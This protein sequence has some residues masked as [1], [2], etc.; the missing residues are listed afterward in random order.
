MQKL[1][2]KSGEIVAYGS[3]PGGS[4]EAVLAFLCF[5]SQTY[6]APLSPGMTETEVLDAL[7]QFNAK[8]LILFHGIECQGVANAFESYAKGGNAT[9]HSAQITGTKPGHFKFTT[10]SVD[11][12]SLTQL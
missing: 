10:E 12:V 5:S 4:A 3:P 8:H 1:G 9:L 11:M 6:M 2:V 7:G